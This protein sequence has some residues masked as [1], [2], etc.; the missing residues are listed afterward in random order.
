MTPSR[1]QGHCWTS[2]L[3]DDDCADVVFMPK[4]AS[5]TP[6]AGIVPSTPPR[7][8]QVFGLVTPPDS[9]S[10]PN[11]NFRSTS[12]PRTPVRHP[13]IPKDT[14][15]LTLSG[16]LSEW[17]SDQST[18]VPFLRLTGLLTPDNTPPRLS[19]PK[20][21]L[22]SDKEEATN[23]S[24]LSLS[25]VARISETSEHHSEVIQNT[26][27]VQTPNFFHDTDQDTSPSNLSVAVRGP[28]HRQSQDTATKPTTD[29]N[30]QC[31]GSTLY[32]IRCQRS[33]KPSA[34]YCHQHGYQSNSTPT[35]PIVSQPTTEV[36][37]QCHELT[38][39]DI[40]CRLPVKSPVQYYYQHGYQSNN[41]PTAPIAPTLT[42]EVNSRCHGLTLHGIQCGR[43]I[44][45]PARYCYQHGSQSNNTTYTSSQCRG[46]TLLAF[47][48]H[49][50]SNLLLNTAIS[51][52][53]K[54]LI[55]LPH[56]PH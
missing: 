56:P 51:M 8:K 38:L 2:A 4:T 30:S 42:I 17:S 24:E 25:T 31:H 32:G 12:P 46:L 26:K 3:E 54:V 53:P 13:D 28:Q 9:Q 20:F 47:S 19:K 29:V 11:S 5:V 21:V 23:K 10:R 39:R 45:P 36:N 1:Y 37:S 33:V 27:S 44:K 7:N 40:Q 43:S 15:P 22:I 16:N 35:I 34:Q 48:A 41:T 18:T 14:K 50:Q 55:P 52:D 49:V 6:L